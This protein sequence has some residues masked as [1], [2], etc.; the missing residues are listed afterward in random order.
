M[1]TTASTW[2]T[3]RK[4]I[5][6]GAC[7]LAALGLAALFASPLK[8]STSYPNRPI[9]LVVPFA[10]GSSADIVARALADGLAQR[11]GQPVVVV[12]RPGG[13]GVVCYG[14][15]LHKPADGYTLI[16]SSPAILTAYHAGIANFHYRDL[17][18]LGG[19]TVEN[20]IVAVR[21]NAPWRDLR[22]LVAFAREQPGMLKVG[23]SGPGSHTQITA[24]AFFAQQNT[25][26]LHV[27]FS[28]AQVVTAL[29]GGEIDAVV[30][31]PS[32][33]LPH[34]QSGTLKIIGTLS[35]QREPAVATVP[36]AIEQGFDFH[37]EVWRALAGPKGLPEEVVATLEAAL[38]E[39]VQGHTFSTRGLRDGFA[40]AFQP[41][42]AFTASL[43][44]EDALV[45]QAMRRLDILKR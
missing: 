20:P 8:T 2:S 45:A 21:A 36:T 3:R 41:R 26:P 11:L 19:V 23:N 40:P 28:T 14:Y 33:I 15:M 39:T 44:A 25:H 43:E 7:G 18:F 10:A 34:V 31:L 16:L 17:A 30:Q 9:E 4:V 6:A 32:A 13:G 42:G 24:F 22:E 27:P 5:S 29:L 12:N 1:K 35:R 38:Q 37:A